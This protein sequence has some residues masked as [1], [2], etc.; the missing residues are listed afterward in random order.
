MGPS[1]NSQGQSLSEISTRPGRLLR[2][3]D[4][5][6]RKTGLAAAFLIFVLMALLSYEV[7]ARY[8]F[9]RPTIWAMETSQLLMCVIVAL[10]GGFSYLYGAHVNVDILVGRFSER[11]RAIVA[12][13]T[14]IF[15][16]IFVGF[17]LLKMGTVTLESLEMKETSGTYFDPP[18][19]PVKI[20][21][22]IGIFL[23]FLQVISR[24]IRTCLKV[25][26]R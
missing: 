24:F 9:D 22:V 18:V 6:T 13:F 11:N 25:M 26:G 3:L 19:Y 7:I 16:F 17:F 14:E 5:I 2:C 21:M 12:I 15:V 20:L 4:Y 23:M 1:S 8:V 10:G